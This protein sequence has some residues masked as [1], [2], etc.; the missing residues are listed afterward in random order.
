VQTIK[1]V[2]DCGVLI[3]KHL[4][5]FLLQTLTKK[6]N[7]GCESPEPDMDPY[8]N[9]LTPDEKYSRLNEEFPDFHIPYFLFWLRS[10]MIYRDAAN[11]RPCR[12]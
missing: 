5:L 2:L 6:E 11:R 1:K 12:T 4:A 8:G 10:V 9:S 3:R 7:K